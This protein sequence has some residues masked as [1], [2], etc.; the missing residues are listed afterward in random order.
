M[1][2]RAAITSRASARTAAAQARQDARGEPAP[3]GEAGVEALLRGRR[4][5]DGGRQGAVAAL[6][7]PGADGGRAPRRGRR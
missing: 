7:A 6:V 4:P 1:A 5:D 2:R 3:L